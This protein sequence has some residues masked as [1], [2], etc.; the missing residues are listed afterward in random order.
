VISHLPNFNIV[1]DVIGFLYLHNLVQLGSILDFRRYNEVQRQ[2][3]GMDSDDILDADCDYIS[4]AMQKQ[5]RDAKTRS[6]AILTWLV[7]R[8]Q[9]AIFNDETGEEECPDGLAR[10]ERLST[11]VNRF[12]VQQCQALVLEKWEAEHR[13]I[14]GIAL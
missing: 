10:K 6:N 14:Q 7:S 12:L 4:Q 11:M 3:D 13:N 5:Y 1:D 9:L 2:D 8:F